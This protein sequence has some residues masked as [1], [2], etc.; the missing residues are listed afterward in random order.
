MA[1]KVVAKFYELERDEKGGLVNVIITAKNEQ[2]INIG[3]QNGSTDYD[4]AKSAINAASDLLKFGKYEHP[5]TAVGIH[6]NNRDVNTMFD[7]N[8]AV[9]STQYV[10]TKYPRPSELE[11]P[12]GWAQLNVRNNRYYLSHLSKWECATRSRKHDFIDA[13]LG[14]NGIKIRVV[15]IN[16][17]KG[18]DGLGVIDKIVASWE[19]PDMD[20]ANKMRDEGIA[21]AQLRRSIQSAVT[22]KAVEEQ[23]IAPANMAINLVILSTG[24]VVDITKHESCTV[25]VHDRRGA[26]ASQKWDGSAYS[27]VRMIEIAQRGYRVELKTK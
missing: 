12:M 18:E 15:P 5:E 3:S 11:H 14:G 16:F 1:K 7:T 25:E 21:K 23:T 2:Y 24:E 26:I 6:F 13:L 4:N 20:K 9:V 22:Q 10:G 17:T 27:R 19:E 8:I